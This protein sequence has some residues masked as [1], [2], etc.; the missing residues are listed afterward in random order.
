MLTSLPIGLLDCA[1]KSCIVKMPT[2]EKKLSRL[3]AVFSDLT[4]YLS[5]DE[6][7]PPGAFDRSDK[8]TNFGFGMIFLTKLA[9]RFADADELRHF[10][11]SA[12]ESSATQLASAFTARAGDLFASLP[13]ATAATPIVA[14]ALAIARVA[15]AV[16]ADMRKVLEPLVLLPAPAASGMLTALPSA[17]AAS[18]RMLRRPKAVSEHEKRLLT[19]KVFWLL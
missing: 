15:L 3:T 10:A 4:G 5:P 2:N 14:Q 9:R 8:P 13:N 16:A 1:S 18:R 6:K 19:L 17:T 11:Q 12:T 7:D